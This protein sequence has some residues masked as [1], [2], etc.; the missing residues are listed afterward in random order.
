MRAHPAHLHAVGRPDRYRP[1]RPWQR[2]RRLHATCH[3]ALPEAPQ[4]EGDQR[5]EP[6]AEQRHHHRSVNR[7]RDGRGLHLRAKHL[8]MLLELLRI[9]HQHRRHICT[10][11][12]QDE[13]RVPH[14]RRGRALPGASEAHQYRLADSVR[15]LG[16]PAAGKTEA[17]RSATSGASVS[18]SKWGKQDAGGVNVKL[19]RVNYYNKKLC[20][21]KMIPS[22]SIS[23]RFLLWSI[24]EYY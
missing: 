13:P 20:G 18:L 16:R 24:L 21:A 1:R 14:L 2:R 8:V 17:D 22:V 3:V 11:V 15:H 9:Q 19:Q 4:P 10:V 7:L 6:R 23:P 5:V 12:H